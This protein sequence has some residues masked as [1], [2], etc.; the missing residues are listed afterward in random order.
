VHTARLQ[1][2]PL[3]HTVKRTLTWSAEEIVA[4]TSSG[5]S[6]GLRLPYAYRLDLHPPFS[7]ESIADN[8]VAFLVAQI[9]AQFRADAAQIRPSRPSNT[10][11]SD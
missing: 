7:G 5:V 8:S 1:S 9:V 4:P 2:C 11:A 6:G 3:Q 10:C